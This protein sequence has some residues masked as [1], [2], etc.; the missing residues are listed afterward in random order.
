MRRT[1]ADEAGSLTYVEDLNI[2][3]YKLSQVKPGMSGNG[4]TPNE[5]GLTIHRWV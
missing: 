4:H 2:R 5:F 1:R 3:D